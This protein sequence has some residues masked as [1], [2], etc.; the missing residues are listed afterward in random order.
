MTRNPIVLRELGEGATVSAQARQ[1]FDGP[2]EVV[3]A[4]G[5]HQLA[6]EL[7]PVMLVYENGHSK[8]LPLNRRGGELYGE[9]AVA[10][11][12]LI[13][14]ERRTTFW[15]DELRGFPPEEAERLRDLL[16]R[17]TGRGRG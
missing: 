5:L 13:C 9:D 8:G 7:W 15:V 10:G 4:R 6:P 12:V 14:Q 1:L 11:D 3:R 16:F 2:W 17:Q